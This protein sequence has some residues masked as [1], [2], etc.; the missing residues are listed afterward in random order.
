MVIVDSNVLVDVLE[1][2]PDRVERSTGR[3]QDVDDP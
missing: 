2:D 1:D 3:M